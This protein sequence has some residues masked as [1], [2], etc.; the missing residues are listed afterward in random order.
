MLWREKQVFEPWK[1]S[2][3]FQLL[4]FMNEIGQLLDS[5]DS[6]PVTR[7]FK[8]KLFYFK[9]F[10]TTQGGSLQNM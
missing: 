2:I 8:D 5:E 1:E 4:V 10:E 6:S 3:A 7:Q 9:T